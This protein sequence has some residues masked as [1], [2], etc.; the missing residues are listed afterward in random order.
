MLRLQNSFERIK[1]I[2]FGA[3]NH[4]RYDLQFGSVEQMLIAHLHDIEIPVCCEPADLSDREVENDAV[5]IRGLP[6]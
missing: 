5:E 4:I 2:I 1:G 6:L 3:F